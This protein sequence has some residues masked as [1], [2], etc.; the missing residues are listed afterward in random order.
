[1]PKNTCRL[2]I[3]VSL[4]LIVLAAANQTIAGS[5]V[6]TNGQPVTTNLKFKIVIPPSLALQV[7]TGPADTLLASP[8]VIENRNVEQS[9]ADDKSIYVTASATV[10]KNGI[11]NVSSGNSPPSAKRTGQDHVEYLPLPQLA[12]GR[13]KLVYKPIDPATRLSSDAIS[14]FTLYSP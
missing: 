14:R 4:V 3:L 13:Y 1:M 10:T 7:K 2:Y 12:S 6:S 9:N 5:R 11:L 8:T